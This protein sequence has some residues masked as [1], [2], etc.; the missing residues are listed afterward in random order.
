MSQLTQN[1]TNNEIEFLKFQKKR[2]FDAQTSFKK[3]Q[4]AKNQWKFWPVESK[5]NIVTNI[6]KQFVGNPKIGLL[7]KSSKSVLWEKT[8]K[9]ISNLWG[10]VKFQSEVD[11][12]IFKSTG[13]FIW[14][15][16]WS[17]IEL[18]WWVVSAISNPVWTG[19]ALKQFGETWI[20]AWL[21][22]LFSTNMW[23]SILKKLWASEKKLARLK[24]GWVFTSKENEV[25][26]KVLWNEWDRI[27]NEPWRLKELIVE[28]WPAEA[29]WVLSW[30]TSTLSKI[31]KISKTPKLTAG[32]DVLSKKSNPIVLQKKWI[33]LWKNITTNVKDK[34]FPQKSLDDII[35]QISQWKSKDIPAFKEALWKID[36][37]NIKEYKDLDKAFSDKIKAI[38]K[39]QDSRLSN[40]PK[41]LISELS[42]TEWKR[43]INFIDEAINDLESVWI[44]ANDLELLKKVDAIK[45][46]EKLSDKDINDLARFYGTTFRK[47]AFN[48]DGTPKSNVSAIRFENNRIWIKK[49][50]RNLL[51]DDTMRLLDAEL[52]NLYDAKLLSTKVVDKVDNLSKKIRERGLLERVWRSIWRWVD[53][54]SGGS[55]RGFLTS[56]IPSNVWNKVLN[57]IDIQNSLQKNLKAIEKLTKQIPKLS[58]DEIIKNTK[59]IFIWRLWLNWSED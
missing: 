24:N 33:E 41:Y 19:K 7:E 38:S 43:S 12:N 14:N 22:K 27:K 2:W 37:S 57:S 32:L 58:D 8:W 36:T 54:V 46:K 29:L 18:W 47:K 25:L 21:N 13:K 4:L 59:N 50:S 10:K 16:P 31:S 9:A 34:L 49:V 42:T 23:Q 20:E 51:P 53:I 3:L 5:P 55:L 11:D 48:T 56:L 35:M 6:W 39:E 30:W 1:L 52:S 28:Q 44:T 17:T 45:S 15:L 26:A 40:D